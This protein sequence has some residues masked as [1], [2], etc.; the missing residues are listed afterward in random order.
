MAPKIGPN[1][2]THIHRLFPVGCTSWLVWRKIMPEKRLFWLQENE[3]RLTVL[4]VLVP[5]MRTAIARRKCC[6][7]E[8]FSGKLKVPATAINSRIEAVCT[9]RITRADAHQNSPH[10][11]RKTAKITTVACTTYLKN[12]AIQSSTLL[13]HQAETQQPRQAECHIHCKN[14]L[15][16]LCTASLRPI[17]TLQ[18]CQNCQ[19][20]TGDAN[21]ATMRYH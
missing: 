5:R 11:E 13:H 4:V 8:W 18:I 3:A 19:N 1:A 15:L 20:S 16:R 21:W 17:V 2:V 9:R 10:G 14:R 7:K 6:D 12:K